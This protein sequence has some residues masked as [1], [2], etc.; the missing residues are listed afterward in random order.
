MDLTF[1]VQ[2][3]AVRAKQLQC[4]NRTPESFP[5]FRLNFDHKVV[6]SELYQGAGDPEWSTKSSFEYRLREADLQSAIQSLQQRKAVIEVCFVDM[7]G[8][9]ELRVGSCAVDLFTICSGPHQFTFT[10]QAEDGTPAG[11]L[12]FSLTM[13]QQTSVQLEFKEVSV[14][15]LPVP[16]PYRIAYH[17]GSVVGRDVE[18]SISAVTP[19]PQWTADG[20]PRLEIRS[21]L[22]VLMNSTVKVHVEDMH[23]RGSRVVVFD[24]PL[25][26]F[27]STNATHSAP[28]KKNAY[29]TSVPGST[30]ANFAALATGIVQFGNLPIFAQFER[31]ENQQGNVHGKPLLASCPT[32]P[33]YSKVP[34][35]LPDM[36]P[37]QAQFEIAQHQSMQPDLMNPEKVNAWGA[38]P[39]AHI[40]YQAGYAGPQPPPSPRYVP[41]YD[42]SQQQPRLPPPPQQQ[43]QPAPMVGMPPP[44][45]Q[46]PYASGNNSYYS[47]QDTSRHHESYQP[48]QQ[49]QSHYYAH[50]ETS[51][52]YN[53]NSARGGMNVIPPQPPMRQQSPMSGRSSASLSALRAKSPL[54]SAGETLIRQHH[55]TV[56]AVEQQQRRVQALA[57]ELHER[58]VAEVSSSE[59][60]TKELEQ[61]EQRVLNELR[62]VTR[63]VEDLGRMKEEHQATLINFERKMDAEK[64]ALINELEDLAALHV[65]VTELANQVSTHAEEDLRIR[66]RSRVE[67]EGARGRFD[68]DTRTLSEV[69]SKIQYRLGQPAPP[70]FASPQ[71]HNTQRISAQPSYGAV[72]G[73]PLRSARVEPRT[74]SPARERAG[75]GGLHSTA[76]S[77]DVSHDYSSHHGARGHSG[78]ISSVVVP[79]MHSDVAD[80]LSAVRMN[81]LYRMQQILKR[82]P[83]CIF[84]DN[85]IL[86][87]ACAN[88][89]PDF[90]V[91]SLVVYHR[92]ELING[93]DTSTGSTALHLACSASAISMPVVDL[94][95]TKGASVT[96]LDN[97][98]LSPFHVAVRN[99]SDGTHNLKKL[100]LLKGNADV[101]G[102]TGRGETPAHLVCTHDRFVDVLRFLVRYGANLNAVANIHNADNIVTPV[103]P[104][105]KSRWYGPAAD[106]C[107]RFLEQGGAMHSFY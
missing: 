10:L 99:M 1:K 66:E 94:L 21:T 22:R 33:S 79:P 64:T 91:V 59:I 6:E 100:L 102:P 5:L 31:G 61:E 47:Q 76:P 11:S 68:Y 49:Q 8:G 86:H 54:A 60:R 80:L 35:R 93:V 89:S 58:T 52:T 32:P 98:G 62:R 2:I 44:P 106:E 67:I 16:A 37:G 18:S 7:R 25:R 83:R 65:Q 103:T 26:E 30:V 55:D 46:Q 36:R 84:E 50:Q 70:S 3:S 43:Q 24:L 15:G 104:L 17:F 63:A 85:N 101:N 51:T 81:D 88:P 13:E 96:V 48:Q 82:A 23:Q 92:P 73:S 53:Y 95:L 78:G 9:R 39:A 28:F 27:V 14:S 41:Q 40:A 72:T 97:D 34:K 75:F 77:L 29:G 69:E 20:L 90:E 19:N 107:R 12:F 45:Q 74:L 56:S 38:Q 87:L 71:I 105:Q 57:Q 4:P 42:V